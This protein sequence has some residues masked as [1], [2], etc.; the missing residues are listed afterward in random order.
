MG[1]VYK[2]VWI[3][4]GGNGDIGATIILQFKQFA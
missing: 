1:E 3:A 4:K 2:E